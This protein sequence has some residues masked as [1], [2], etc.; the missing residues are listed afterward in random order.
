MTTEPCIVAVDPGLTGAVAFYF[1]SLPDRVTV[2]DLPVIAGRFDVHALDRRLR[3]MAP[4]LGVIEAVNAMPS[5]GAGG[6]RRTMGASSAFNFGRGLGEV[7]TVLMLAG[8]PLHRFT[9]GSW[10]KFFKIP[11]KAAGGEDIARREAIRL[12]PASA[13]RF[14]LKKH[15]GRADAALIAAYAAAKLLRESAE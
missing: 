2:E 10:K 11:G 4:T 12:F 13:E 15:H 6:Q 9:P 14:A 8:M 1:P 7:E 3:Q 5:I